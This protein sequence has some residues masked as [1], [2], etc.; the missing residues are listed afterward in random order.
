MHPVTVEKP[1]TAMLKKRPMVGVETHVPGRIVWQQRR[2]AAYALPTPPAERFIGHHELVE[3]RD[4]AWHTSM[5]RRFETVAGA[6]LVT[7]DA[8]CAAIQ[9]DYEV[10]SR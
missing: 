5:G 3:P 8:V 4:F 10:I 9:R 1:A 2:A 7:L 6:P